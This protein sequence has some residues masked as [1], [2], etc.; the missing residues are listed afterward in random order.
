MSSPKLLD[1]KMDR[2]PP[3]SSS[4]SPITPVTRVKVSN[5]SSL[6]T[7]ESGKIGC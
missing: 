4:N 5:L 3:S 6:T 1:S 7:E 2:S